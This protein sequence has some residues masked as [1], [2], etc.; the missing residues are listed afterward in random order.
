MFQK[1][2]WHTAL[3][4]FLHLLYKNVHST[5]MA[6]NINRDKFRM[7]TK[8]QA[9]YCQIGYTFPLNI[10]RNTKSAAI[11]RDAERV[12]G[13]ERITLLSAIL[14]ILQSYN[15]YI[16]YGNSPFIGIDCFIYYIYYFPRFKI[17]IIM[18]LKIRKYCDMI[19]PE[20]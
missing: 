8:S 19:F 9:A 1:I 15:P 20:K 2:L 16:F 17:K 11:R 13:I 18:V 5:Y 6:G 12:I 3:L 10:L 14:S 7:S 4:V